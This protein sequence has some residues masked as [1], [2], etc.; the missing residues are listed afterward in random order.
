MPHDVQPA[1]E[2]N[3]TLIIGLTPLETVG[4]FCLPEDIAELCGNERAALFGGPESV[5]ILQNPGRIREIVACSPAGSA[6]AA[7]LADRLGISIRADFPLTSALLHA[8]KEALE[9]KGRL[10]ILH[11]QYAANRLRR[12]ISEHYSGEITVGSFFMM[13]STVMLPG[14]LRFSGEDELIDAA[15]GFDVILADPFYFRALGGFRGRLIPLPHTA[16]SGDYYDE[17][18]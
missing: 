15:A 4:P 16:V 14:D 17:K 3:I 1:S 12:R 8:E 5:R 6:A 13:E 18:V 7:P 2:R 9:G 11:Q 10:L